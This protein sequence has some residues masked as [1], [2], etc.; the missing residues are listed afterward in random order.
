MSN[1]TRNWKN[2]AL[3]VSALAI[4]LTGCQKQATGQVAAVVNGEEVT[5]QEINAEIGNAQI[6]EGADKQ[7]VQRA[8]LQQIVDRRLLAKT[9]KDEGLDK[10]G[11][12]L[13][14]LRKMQDL[15]LVQQLSQQSAKTIKV[16]TAADADKFVAA[17]PWMFADRQMLG[18][19]RIRFMAPSI[20]NAVKPL[21]P[22][23]T[24]GAVVAKLN[25]TQIK[26]QRDTAQFDTARLD[27]G[28]LDR[29]KSLPPGEPL[30]VPEGSIVS[31]YVLTS[32]KP[33]PLTGEQARPLAVQAIRNTAMAGE[34]KRRMDAAKAA[35]KIE[36]QPG[37]APT[38]PV[39]EKK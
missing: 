31:V 7:A 38:P 21:I 6:P 35:A 16:P 10:T 17:N 34:L 22:L 19:D 37:F 12:Y 3:A 33:A 24:M 20:E 27:K 11:D 39:P 26:F 25:E 29:I 30:I 32:T 28:M 2:K 13:I 5:L 8:A 4:V 14:Q 1:T 9:A 23:H 18:F 36:Y 15:L